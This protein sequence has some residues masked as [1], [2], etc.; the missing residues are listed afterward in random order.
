[1]SDDLSPTRAS[2]DELA[3]TY[4]A[5]LFDELAGKPLDRHLLDRF[6][7]SVRA[8]GPASTADS[9]PSRFF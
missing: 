4:A 6:A 8:R 7:E 3:A 5:R 1:M 2:Y 9:T